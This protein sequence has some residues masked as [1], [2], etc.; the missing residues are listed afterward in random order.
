MALIGT[1]EAA[2]RMGLSVGRLTAMI[3]AGILRAQKIGNTW[4]VEESEVVRVSKLN[5]KPGRPRKNKR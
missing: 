5:R 1:D 3:R 4:I 2:R